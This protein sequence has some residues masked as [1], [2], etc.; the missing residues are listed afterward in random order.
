[1]DTTGDMYNEFVDAN[2][3]VQQAFVGNL[4]DLRSLKVKEIGGVDIKD[5]QKS[6][7]GFRG[8]RIVGFP[9]AA[10][11]NS[12][13]WEDVLP[14]NAPAGV[15]RDGNKVMPPAFLEDMEVELEPS[16]GGIFGGNGG[17]EVDDLTTLKS[18][19]RAK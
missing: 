12:P 3:K 1:M 14:P 10:D 8:G 9:K 17:G 19:R 16:R 2:G 5:L 4:A 15:N 11:P 6:V 7:K 18:L 13:S